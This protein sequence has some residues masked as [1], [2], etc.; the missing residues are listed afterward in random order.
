MYNVSTNVILYRDLEDECV[1]CGGVTYEMNDKSGT[2]AH[3][4]WLMMERVV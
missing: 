1:R 3:Q 2:G 4:S